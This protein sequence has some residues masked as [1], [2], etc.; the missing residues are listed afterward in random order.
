M[1]SLPLFWPM[2]GFMVA[3]AFTPGPNNIMLAASGANFGFRR[4][5]PHMLGVAGGI[6]GL[7]LLVGL[8]LGVLFETFPLVRQVLRVG[9]L[10]FILYLA[11][12]I[13]TSG[14]STDAKGRGR[15]MNFIEAASFQLI[16]PKGIVMAISVTTTFISPDANFTAQFIV[17]LAAFTVI[18]FA[19]V[20]TWAGFGLII[21][22]LI[23]TDRRQRLFNITMA[24]LLVA[25]ILPV[26]ADMLTP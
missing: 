4:T 16:N 19:A 14:R 25:S 21:G 11:W 2:L 13:A 20:T 1:T 9:A 12:R 18:T 23:Q 10:S 22:R 3:A 7:M 5:I 8:G 15:P 6:I 17:L 24:V 26:A